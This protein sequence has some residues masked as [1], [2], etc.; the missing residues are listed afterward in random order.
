VPLLR[1]VF[2]ANSFFQYLDLCTKAGRAVALRRR[3]D[4]PARR[5]DEDGR[6][7]AYAGKSPAE[8]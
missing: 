2:E 8:R 4:A 3:V 6:V 7:V 5:N 1:Y